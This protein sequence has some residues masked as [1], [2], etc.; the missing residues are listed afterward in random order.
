MNIEDPTQ[1]ELEKLKRFA[2]IPHMPT[3]IT[4]ALRKAVSGE[5][6]RAY[7]WS[8]KPHRLLYD[9][10]REIERINHLIGV[11]DL[12]LIDREGMRDAADSLSGVKAWLHAWA[13]HVGNCQGGQACTCGLTRAHYDVGLAD[14]AIAAIL[15]EQS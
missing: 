7:D 13:T 12:V 15:G 6:P 14:A 1:E 11:G 2:G 8:D 9:A 3:Q 4:Y 5:G 10:C